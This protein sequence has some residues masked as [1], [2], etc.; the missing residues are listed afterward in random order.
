M[1]L[2]DL[3][4]VGQLQQRS[5]WAGKRTI[6]LFLGG[7]IASCGAARQ[8]YASNWSSLFP[9]QKIVRV[10][11]RQAYCHCA[12][13]GS[14]YFHSVRCRHNFPISIVAEERKLSGASIPDG[15][16]RSAKSGF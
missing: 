10:P 3:F 6:R 8:A 14:E 9:K 7:R 2:G 1:P 4:V 15:S 11:A 5:R 12:S 16:R 13:V